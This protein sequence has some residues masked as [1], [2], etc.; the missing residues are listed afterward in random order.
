MHLSGLS[1][2]TIPINC[3][4]KRLG[5]SYLLLGLLFGLSGTL[6]SYIIRLELYSTGN[7]IIPTSNETFYNLSFTLHGLFMIFFVVMPGVYGGFENYFVPIFQGLPEV[8]HPRVNTFSFLLLPFSYAC[9][10][11]SSASED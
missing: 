8:S 10:I 5:I 6:W 11:L 4:H 2:L 3:N 9:I 1:S 7:R